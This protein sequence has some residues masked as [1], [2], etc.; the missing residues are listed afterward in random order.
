M[1]PRTYTD[2]GQ[3]FSPRSLKDTGVQVTS[4]SGEFPDNIIH[5]AIQTDGSWQEREAAMLQLQGEIVFIKDKHAHEVKE[6]HEQVDSLKYMLIQIE[7]MEKSRAM[8]PAQ[9]LRASRGGSDSFNL[10][11]GMEGEFLDGFTS[12]AIDAATAITPR[13]LAETAQQTDGEHQDVFVYQQEIKELNTQIARYKTLWRTER[14]TALDMTK[15]L[16]TTV[17]SMSF[18]WEKELVEKMDTVANKLAAV[19]ISSRKLAL[20]KRPVTDALSSVSNAPDLEEPVSPATSTSPV[21]QNQEK[22]I[23]EKIHMFNEGKIK[24]MNASQSHGQ[25]AFKDEKTAD[26]SGVQASLLYQMWQSKS[27]AALGKTD[28]ASD[29]DANER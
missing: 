12:N 18:K 11:I 4:E 13:S 24:S 19:E 7:D 9:A 26:V 22:E 23:R 25:L 6:L 29:T 2:S 5:T 17:A 14:A 20:L 16:A 1:T 28:E 15:N 21:E 8:T 3:Q 27:T 10:G